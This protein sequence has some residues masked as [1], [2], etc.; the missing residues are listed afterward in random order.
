[1]AL[2]KFDLRTFEEKFLGE[3]VRVVSFTSCL[4]FSYFG[5]KNWQTLY[6]V[7]HPSDLQLLTFKP[8]SETDEQVVKSESVFR[9]VWKVIYSSGPIITSGDC[10]LFICAVRQIFPPICKAIES[11]S[12]QMKFLRL[13]TQNWCSIP[14]GSYLDCAKQSLK[15]G[16]NPPTRSPTKS[17]S[18]VG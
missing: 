5:G 7:C 8:S 3:L 17:S 9:K 6:L 13:P 2:V 16:F 11:N 18:K 12:S 1:M 10:T 4:E 14:P 15:R